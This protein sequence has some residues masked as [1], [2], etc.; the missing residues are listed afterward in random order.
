[1]IK[2]LGTDI[3]DIGRIESLIAKYGEHFLNKVFT[4][5]EIA[6]CSSRARPGLHYAGRWAAKEAFYKALPRVC[7]PLSTWKSVEIGVEQGSGAPVLSI[8]SA[9]L[10]QSF[11]KQGIS[12]WYVSISHEKQVCIAVVAGE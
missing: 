4:P 6:Y 3:V 7:Q 11:S 5:S 1:M 12:A 2:G 8:L 10:R 9:A